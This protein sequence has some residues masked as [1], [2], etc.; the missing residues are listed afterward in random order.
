MLT[1]ILNQQTVNGTVNNGL[2]VVLYSPQAKSWKIADFGLTS[3]LKGDINAPVTTELG[4]GTGGYRAPELLGEYSKY[5]HKVDI[6]A[7]GC[8]LYELS[9]KK[10]AFVDDWNVREFYISSS[11]STLQV[12]LPLLP[13]ILERHLSECIREMTERYPQNRPSCTILCPMIQSY[14]T[15]LSLQGLQ[16]FIS[17]LPEYSRWKKFVGESSEGVQGILSDLSD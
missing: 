3:N 14:R 1:E 5:T 15:L 8:I 13:R 12:S 6:W 10:K 4:R 17:I 9:V 7:L 2:I 16:D 11:S